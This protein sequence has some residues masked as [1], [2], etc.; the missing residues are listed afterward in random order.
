MFISEDSLR[1]FIFPLLFPF[2]VTAKPLGAV[3]VAKVRVV[4]SGRGRQ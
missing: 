4:G 3:I 2:C 1:N